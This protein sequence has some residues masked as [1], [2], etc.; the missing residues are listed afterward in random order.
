[1]ENSTS[2]AVVDIYTADIEKVGEINLGNAL[3]LSEILR[4][5]TERLYYGQAGPRQ[6]NKWSNHC[7]HYSIFWKT[8]GASIIIQLMQSNATT[9]K[10]LTALEYNIAMVW[11]T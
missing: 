9:K 3:E 1:M 5:I 6:G 11:T 2:G 10:S 7:L 8:A 4:F